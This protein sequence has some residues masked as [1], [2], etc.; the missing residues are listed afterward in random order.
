VHNDGANYGFLDGHAKW[1]KWGGTIAA[2]LPGMHNTGR[3]HY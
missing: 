2:P 1:L 3:W